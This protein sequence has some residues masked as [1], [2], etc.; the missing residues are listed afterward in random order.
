MWARTTLGLAL[1]ALLLA[2]AAA[3]AAVTRDDALR[4]AVSNQRVRAEAIRARHPAAS[5]ARIGRNWVVTLFYR[6]RAI[7]Q[8][9]VDAASGRVSHVYT[10][11]QAEFPLARGPGSGVA[12]RKLGSLWAW[13]PLSLVFVLAFFDWRRPRRLLHL[14]L[15]AVALFGVSYAFFMKGRL[16]ASVPLSY[17]PLAYL[18]VRSLVAGFRPRARAGPL[19]RLP[20]TGLIWLTLALLAARV[21]LTL[22]DPFVMDVGVAS[23]QGADRILHGLTLYTRGGNHFDTYG[24]LTYLAY[25]PFVLIWPFK[26]S[27]ANPPAA[28]A[29]AIFFDVATVAGLVVLGRR[30]RD[31]MLGWALALAWVACPFTALSLACSSNDTLVAALLVWGLVGIRSG[32]ASGL[33]G[34]AAAAAKLTPLLVVPLFARGSARRTAV[35]I[36]AAA[37]VIAVSL[38]PLLP[39]GGL[40]EFYDTTIGFQLHRTSPFSIWTQHP[41]LHALQSV[42]KAAALLL[43]VAVAFV[44]RRISSTGQLA[45]LATAVLVAAQIPL[46]HWFYLYI[47]WALPLYCVA[48]FTEHA[49]DERLGA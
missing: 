33:A 44:P 30:L 27:Q 15:A 13:L 46:Q 41:D 24:P 40:R 37:I 16:G 12:T 20:A 29:A 47:V 5:I 21:L 31:T 49:A 1:C 32:A 38:I 43:A 11:T 35:A 39:A 26:Q 45:A 14:D 34:G 25:V 42:L 28:Q 19:T 8:A 2:P 48:L 4:I 18:L 9:S 22:L 3:H 23:V 10:G 36:G 7:A 6:D 17:P